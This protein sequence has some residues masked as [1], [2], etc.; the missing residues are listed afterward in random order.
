M[1]SIPET[2]SAM[3]KMDWPAST[4]PISRYHLLTKPASNGIPAIPAAAMAKATI[5]SG[6]RLPIPAISEMLSV[7]AS[8]WIA[9]AQKNSVSFMNACAGIWS[10]PPTIASSERI[11][12]PR[13]IYES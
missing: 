3:A 11:P 1:L 13:T 2:S 8:T 12:S 6:I 4:L 10:N 5:V 7:W 9:P